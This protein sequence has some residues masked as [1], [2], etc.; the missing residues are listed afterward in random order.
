MTRPRKIPEQ[1]LARVRRL[2][3]ILS[4]ATECGD[5]TRAKIAL[6]DLRPILERY[7]HSHRVLQAYL[8]LYETALEAW[9]LDL[10]KR[11]FDFVR[12]EANENTRLYLEA[13][14]LLAVAHLRTQDLF[15]A[16]PLM[17]EALR[18]DN[19]IKSRSQ[20]DIFRREAIARFD[21]DGALAA[22]AR[23]HPEAMHEA[24]VHQ[25][26][27]ELLRKGLNEQ[28]IEEDLGRRIPQ[29]V[30]EFIM[31]VDVLSRKLLPHETRLLLTSP[32]DV[33]KNRQVARLVYNAAKHRMYRLVCDEHS[34]V[35][36][37]WING[38]LDAICS[39]GYVA[40]AVVA[41]LVDIRVSIP[42]V[43]VGL[44]ALLMKRGITSF[45]NAN[46][47]RRFMD[48]RRKKPNKAQ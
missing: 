20:R 32:A 13:T 31:K 35:Y 44:S 42:A 48:L 14:V 41:V 1:Q 39:R 5:L 29:E 25:G 36:Q 17:A 27:L 34:E 7:H 30:K 45:C 3:D 15:S 46:K 18:N 21:Q 19:I 11:G 33:V 6:N 10:A 37:A 8:M 9:D 24:Q 38:G 28:D 47:P 43:A 16:E 22:M 23:L 2:E 26:A 4:A 40:S 12:R